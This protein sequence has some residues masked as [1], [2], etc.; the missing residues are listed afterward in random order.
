MAPAPVR[1]A[2]HR[3]R[4]ARRCR[5]ACR[6]AHR[7][8]KSSTGTFQRSSAAST[9]R[10]SARSGV[11]SAAVLPFVSAVSR[12]AIAMASA[13]SSAL[14]ASSNDN[15]ASALS[16]CAANS[17]SASSACQRSVA[18]AGRKRFRH[19]PVAAVRR[20]RAENRP[21]RRARSRS[22]ATTPPSQIADDRPPARPGRRRHAAFDHVPRV[23]IEIGVEPRQHDRAMRQP[24]DGGDQLGGRRHRAGRAGGDHRSVAFARRAVSPPRRSGSRGAPPA[25]SCR[26]QRACA[27]QVSRAIFRNCSVSCQ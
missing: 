20:R 1:R 21:P 18:A 11:T 24:G 6:A 9:R 3:P 22:A 10:A 26:A 19:Q 25:R 7:R 2:R 15:P 27:G 12:S 14:A 4:A 17:G 16:S 13:S 5:P 8:R 23:V